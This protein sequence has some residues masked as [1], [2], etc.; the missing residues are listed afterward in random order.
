MILDP[1]KITDI[2][3]LYQEDFHL[4]TCYANVHNLFI[5]Y[6]TVFESQDLWK[7]IKM[8]FF[9]LLEKKYQPQEDYLLEVQGSKEDRYVKYVVYRVVINPRKINK[10]G[11]MRNNKGGD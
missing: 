6:Q 11:G 5:V 1:L 7:I 8:L 3:Y 2:T 10:P 9:V 4:F